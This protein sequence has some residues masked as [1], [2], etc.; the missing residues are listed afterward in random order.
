MRQSF[1]QTVPAAFET[2][3]EMKQ[4]DAVIRRLN[5]RRQADAQGRSERQAGTDAPAKRSAAP[6][7]D[8]VP[9]WAADAGAGGGEP[10][11]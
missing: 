7:T 6:A 5:V 10:D 8:D 9:G 3:Q 11:D 1:R 2:L 4:V